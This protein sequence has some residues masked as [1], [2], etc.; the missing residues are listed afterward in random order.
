M[1]TAVTRWWL[2]R[3]APVVNP[4]RQI[5]GQSDI[6]CDTGNAAVFTGVA[7]AL[8]AAAAWYATPLSRTQRTAAALRAARRSPAHWA[9]PAIEPAFM[10]QHFGSW[11][12]RPR[13]DILGDG[14][15]AATRFWLAPAY[16]APPG[17]ES[18]AAL[19]ARVQERLLALSV[20]HRGE[21]VVLV[22]HGGPIRA[23]L[24]LALGLAPPAALPFKI[25]TV[26]VTRLDW[27]EGTPALWR[28]W[29]TNW[30]PDLA[31][32]VPAHI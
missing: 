27:I 15:P 14:D 28:V 12:G 3:H 22:C 13:S 23:A 24:A 20:Q 18:F 32:M 17:G 2:V 4:S 1:S 5:Y 10:E 29:F 16:E 7:E 30:L 6:D 25:D 26:S 8:P 9:D 11:Q 21:D 19:C 31:E